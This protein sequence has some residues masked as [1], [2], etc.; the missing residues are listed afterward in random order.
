[1]RTGFSIGQNHQTNYPSLAEGDT[2]R[3]LL[4]DVSQSRD[5][6]GERERMPD[7]FNAGDTVTKSGVYKA[8]HAQQHT[9]AH[10]VTAIYG[11]TFP[12]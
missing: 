2:R 3:I 10:Y 4:S 12:A 9:P 6:Q 7:I 1:V 11:D 8:V 5:E